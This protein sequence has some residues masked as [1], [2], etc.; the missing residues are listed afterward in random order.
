MIRNPE[1][2][3]KRT[4]HYYHA[5]PEKMRA[6]HRIKYLLKLGHL[7]KPQFCECC[8]REARLDGH[9]EDYTKPLEVLWLCRKCHRAKG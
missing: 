2:A 6:K 1:R 3:K 9:H 4:R 8:G 7:T 5:N